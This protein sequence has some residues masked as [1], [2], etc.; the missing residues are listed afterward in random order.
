M[1]I[2]EKIYAMLCRGCPN[3]KRCHDECDHCDDYYEV[4]ENENRTE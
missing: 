4:L 2:E 3:E 1:T